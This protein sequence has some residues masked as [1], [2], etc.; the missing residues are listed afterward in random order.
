MKCASKKSGFTL[1]ELLVVVSIIGLLISLLLPAVQAA[2]EAARRLQCTNNIKQLSLGCLN[3]ESVHGFLPT[4]GWNYHWQ[5]DPDMGFGRRQPGGW[6]YNILPYI[7][8]QERH[9]IGTGMS[10]D[11]KKVAFAQMAEIPLAC[12][13]C[14][15]RRQ[16]TLYPSQPSQRNAAA[17]LNTP[18]TD[19]AGNGGT[20]APDFYLWTL[21]GDDPR[22]VDAEGFVWPDYSKYNGVFI[23][24]NTVRVADIKDGASNTYLLGE[25]YMDPDNYL[26]G[27]DDADN[28]APYIGYD[29]DTERWSLFDGSYS[30][31]LQD[32]PGRQSDGYPYTP[33][34]NFNSGF[35]SAHSSGFN[36]A[37]CDGSVRSVSY[38][39]DATIHGHLCDRKDGVPMDAK[40]LQ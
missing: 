39:I 37:L 15:T 9:D 34:K 23:P 5:G 1:V 12:L 6:I 30:A 20:V 3:H 7:E 27:V 21:A 40:K 4:A 2:R 14:P 25:K 26:N 38:S 8:Q 11:E 18:H 33:G 32:T 17:A 16:P 13:N 19:Y 29:W 24:T 28:N 35:G 22:K 31:P 36:M 10:L